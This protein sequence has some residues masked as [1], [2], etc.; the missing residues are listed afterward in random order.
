MLYGPGRYARDWTPSWLC[1]QMCQ[2]CLLV[3][4][5]KATPSSGSK[6]GSPRVAGW[7]SQEQEMRVRSVA[8]G[9]RVWNIT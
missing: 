7:K 6:V 2:S 1:S 8:C 5:Q 4:S 9:Q 3:M